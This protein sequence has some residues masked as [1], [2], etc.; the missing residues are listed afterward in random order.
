VSVWI[1]L[2]ETRPETGLSF[3]SGSHL[4]GRPIQQALAESGR[5]GEVEDLLILAREKVP[6]AKLMH[7][8]VGNGEAFIFDGRTWHGSRHE[9]RARRIAV[10]LQYAR[11]DR[12]VR[13]PLNH[14]DWPFVYVEDRRPPCIVVAGSA[15][16]G[17]NDLV[18]P[19]VNML[20]HQIHEFSVPVSIPGA[21]AASKGFFRGPTPPVAEMECHAS[22]LMPG[23]S[24]HK[25]HR[26]AEEELLVV[27]EGEATLIL[28]DGPEAAAKDHV[29]LGPG[30]F[31]YYP[32]NRWHT[33]VN[34]GTAPLSYLVMK[35]VGPTARKGKTLGTKIVSFRETLSAPPAEDKVKAP[36]LNEPTLWLDILHSH[37]AV[38]TPG[39]GYDAHADDHDVAIILLDGNVTTL[40]RTVKAPA[41]IYHPAGKLHG[42]VNTGEVPA[43][44]LV[45]EFHRAPP[46]IA[47]RL[48][49][50]K[51]SLAGRA[52]R[53]AYRLARGAVRR[54]RKLVRGK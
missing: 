36:L 54:A 9:G 28:P 17:L 35:W 16:S 19:P 53:K 12:R 4:A 7:P 52:A 11:A 41:M 45:F 22:I 32:A 31:S 39:F 8:P 26:H 48:A 18:P 23:E 29:P 21:R 42:L 24:P 6:G 10:L 34:L 47:G 20:D 25:P 38:R 30:E 40:G 50:L 51:Y 1:G 2:E 44:Y 13:F 27:L 49:R 43:R 33:L 5:K 14:H 37:F 46:G 15:P 3:I